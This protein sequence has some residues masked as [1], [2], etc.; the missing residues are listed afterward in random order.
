MFV[1][2]DNTI[3]Q[4]RHVVFTATP[5]ALVGPMRIQGAW[6]LFQVVREK[7]RRHQTLREVAPR[8]RESLRLQREQRAADKLLVKLGRLYRSITVCE[9]PYRTDLCRGS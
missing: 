2:E 5:G 8:I 6:W 3:A 4:L 1:A 7:P 9:P